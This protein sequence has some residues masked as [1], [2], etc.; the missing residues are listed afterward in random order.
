MIEEIQR[1]DQI[2]PLDALEK[3]GN[4]PPLSGIYLVQRR[5]RNHGGLGVLQDLGSLGRLIGF[6]LTTKVASF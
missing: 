3:I 6:V 5:R 1:R 4:H 2:D